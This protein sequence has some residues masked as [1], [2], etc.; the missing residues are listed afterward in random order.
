MIFSI[1]MGADYSFYV[2]SIATYAPAFFGYNDSV[3]ARVNLNK[4]YWLTLQDVYQLICILYIFIG[5]KVSQTSQNER[6][7]CYTTPLYSV[8]CPQIFSVYSGQ[9]HQKTDI[10]YVITNNLHLPVYV[11]GRYHEKKLGQTKPIVGHNLPPLIEIG[12]TYLKI[13]VRQLP[14]LPYH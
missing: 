7:Y 5:H 11:Q 8:Q 4:L 10:Y 12:L 14:C 2:K 13:Q 1:A 3:L 9:V 6:R